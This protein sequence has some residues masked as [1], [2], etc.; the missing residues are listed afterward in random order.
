MFF[1]FALF[2]VFCLIVWDRDSYILGWPK[3]NSKAVSDLELLFF[4]PSPLRGE[5]IGL[6]QVYFFFPQYIDA[7][8]EKV[9]S[10]HIKLQT[11]NG[12]TLWTKGYWVVTKD[13]ESAGEG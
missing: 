7:W 10:F 5:I 3:T 6:P 9:K 8:S 13:V 12:H 4:P 2:Y 1:A 11:F